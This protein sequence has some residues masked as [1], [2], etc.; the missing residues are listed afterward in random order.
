MDSLTVILSQLRRGMWATSVD[1][2]DAYLHVLFHKGYRRFLASVQGLDFPVQ[3]FTV[4]SV[5]G[6]TGGYQAHESHGS[7]PEETWDTYL[8]VP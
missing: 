2:L 4:R 1:L 5:N 8:H 7:R 6:S 3:G